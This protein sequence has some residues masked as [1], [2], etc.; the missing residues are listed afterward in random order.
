MSAFRVLDNDIKLTRNLD[1]YLLQ[2]LRKLKLF[3]VV[4]LKVNSNFN[5]P[6][7]KAHSQRSFYLGFLTYTCLSRSKIFVKVIKSGMHCK[8]S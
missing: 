7:F 8:R 6:S 4:L 2:L 3:K 1:P 5:L